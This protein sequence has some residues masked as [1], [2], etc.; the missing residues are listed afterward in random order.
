ML[1]GSF[2]YVEQQHP[3]LHPKK[4]R[5]KEKHSKRLLGSVMLSQCIV[6]SPKDQSS[7]PLIPAKIGVWDMS[8]LRT[9][10]DQQTHRSTW[11]PVGLGP[12]S[13]TINWRLTHNHF[14][15][16]MQFTRGLLLVESKGLPIQ[17][18][19]LHLQR[20]ISLPHGINWRFTH[21]QDTS[22]MECNLHVASC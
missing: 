8:L 13:M 7:K 19:N 20:T 2:W 22:Q 1:S 9:W 11:W 4:K 18:Q 12:M 21:N 5:N 15:N 10:K 3:H 6:I 16:G 14:P 17:P